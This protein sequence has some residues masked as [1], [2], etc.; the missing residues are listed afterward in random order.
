MDRTTLLLSAARFS[1]A[2]ARLCLGPLMPLLSVSL[3]LSNDEKRALLSAYSS[4]YILTQIGGGLLADRYGAS[5]VIASAVGI[6]SLILLYITSATSAVVWANAFFCLGLVAG[7]LF[8]AGSTAISTHVPFERRA[9]AAAIVDAA[10]AAGTTVAA[11]AP[12]IADRFG[13][14]LVYYVTS[15]A[16]AVVSVGALSLSSKRKQKLPGSNTTAEKYP[17][18]SL[19]SPAALST[20]LCHSADNF[21]KYS[22]N[23]WAATML[24][25]KHG[26]SPSMIGLILGTQEAVGVVSR[27]LVG[28][29][30]SSGASSSFARRGVTS[31]LAFLVQ[32]V[33]LL[34]AFRASTPTMT[35]IMFVVSAIA[36]GAHSVGFRP[37]YFEASPEHAGSVSGLGN[38]VASLASAVGPVVV[39]SISGWNRVGLVMILVNFVGAMAAMAISRAGKSKRVMNDK[40][41][42]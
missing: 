28:M 17:I 4:G 32:G 18:A 23:A 7:P 10:A 5:T 1:S 27:L 35:A 22:V 41:Y 2:I 24:S 39:G 9:S 11:L 31:A 13:W 26:A 36:V 15:I 20:Y 19:L 12:M 34:A 40:T 8:P 21:T 38:T 30:F 3:N 25:E 29:A 37:I 42:Q 14:K 6:S 33:A 16:L